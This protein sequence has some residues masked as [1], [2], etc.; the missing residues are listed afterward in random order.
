MSDY[1]N[2][3]IHGWNGGEC[4]V[5]PIDVVT[6]WRRGGDTKTN[7]AE[8]VSW[9]HVEAHQ[10]G[11]K[12][13]IIAFQVVKRHVEPKVIWVNEHNSLLWVA[14]Q[15]EQSARDDA[16][17]SATRIAVRYIEAVNEKD[18]PHD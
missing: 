14:H 16:V 17:S 10:F 8:S 15:S 13:D 12:D 3:Q 6:F 4:P 1:Y 11:R 9:N 2:G 5:H 7:L 18:A